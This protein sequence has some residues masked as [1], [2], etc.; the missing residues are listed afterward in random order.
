MNGRKKRRG[1]R[2]TSEAEVQ[3]FADELK[4]DAKTFLILT[5]EKLRALPPRDRARYLEKLAAHTL[6][7]NIERLA[8]QEGKRKTKAP[9]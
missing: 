7:E 8:A 4:T 3:R 9:K 6:Q 2:E 5:A 1:T